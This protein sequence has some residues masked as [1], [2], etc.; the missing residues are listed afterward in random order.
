MA[1]A[2]SPPIDETSIHISKNKETLYLNN[3]SV[4]FN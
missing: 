1:D 2:N 4:P 3:T